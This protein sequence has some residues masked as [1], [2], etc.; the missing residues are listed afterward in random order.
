MAAAS[1]MRNLVSRAPQY[2]WV[3]IPMRNTNLMLFFSSKSGHV[4]RAV[5]RQVRNKV[6]GLF[7]FLCL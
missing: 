7:F 6:R 3:N 4:V 5:S 1:T 2:L